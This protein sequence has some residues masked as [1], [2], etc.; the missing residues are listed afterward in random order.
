M[1]ATAASP[2]PVALPCSTRGS[3]ARDGRAVASDRRREPVGAE[4][5]DDESG[6][7]VEQG[8]GRPSSGSACPVALRQLLAV[9][10]QGVRAGAGGGEDAG[11][12][13]VDDDAGRPR[14]TSSATSAP[15]CVGSEARAAGCPQIATARAV[16]P[17]RSAASARAAAS[18]GASGAAELVERPS[19]SPLLVVDDRDAAPGGR[20]D[21][22]EPMRDPGCLELGSRT[23]RRS[24]RPPWRARARRALA[25]AAPGPRSAPC[26][27][28]GRRRSAPGAWRQG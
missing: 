9:R 15:S 5:D 20:G 4:R 21:R 24:R 18:P 23:R 10:L 6:P 12:A 7:E 16:R 2:A 22:D 14:P 17:S 13:R 1:A 28:P 19:V 25:R 27:P 8:C 11:T 3:R 26:R